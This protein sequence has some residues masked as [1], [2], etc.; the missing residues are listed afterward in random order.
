MHEKSPSVNFDDLDPKFAKLVMEL[1]GE[2]ILACFNCGYCTGG[3]P[4][5]PYEMNMRKLIQKVIFGFSEEVLN[6]KLIWFCSECN[7]CGERCPQKVKPYKIVIAL[8]H[9]AI[10][11]GIIPLIYNV[12]AQNLIKSGRVVELSEAIDLRREQLELPVAGLTLPEKVLNEINIILAE[13]SF[14]EMLKKKN[15][16]EKEE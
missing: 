10:E 1:L 4:V 12:M 16:Q 8:R 9:I 5:V 2:D 15:D 11:R 7:L 6:S 14:N 3:C 13:T